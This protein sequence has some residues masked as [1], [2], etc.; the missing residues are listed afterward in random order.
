[1]TDHQESEPRT[2]AE[3]LMLEFPEGVE[4]PLDPEIEGMIPDDLPGNVP[5]DEDEYLNQLA[6]D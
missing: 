4:F 1:M 5:R 3:W 6:D 2:K